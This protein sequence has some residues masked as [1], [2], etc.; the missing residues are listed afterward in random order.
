MCPVGHDC[1]MPGIETRGHTSRLWVMVMVS[2]DG[3]EVGLTSILD[4]WQFF[5][6]VCNKLLRKI[7]VLTC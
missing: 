5:C 4:L 2:K 1:R 7:T 6:I 3:K